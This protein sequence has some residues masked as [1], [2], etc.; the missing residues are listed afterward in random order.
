MKA[1]NII[2]RMTSNAE[3]QRKFKDFVQDMSWF[4][5]DKRIEEE[6]S[7]GFRP[8]VHAEILL[9]NWLD[10]TTAD[11]VHG[12]G[13]IDHSRFWNDWA[14]IGSSKPT[15][16]LCAYYFQAHRS[17][18]GYRPSHGNLYMPWRGPDVSRSTVQQHHGPGEVHLD[19]FVKARQDI[20]NRV[21][22]L[23]REEA[24]DVISKK[25]RSTYKRYDSNTFS[26]ALSASQQQHLSRGA[27]ASIGSR[28][29]EQAE[30]DDAASTITGSNGPRGHYTNDDGIRHRGHVVTNR[31]VS[32]AR[33]Y[34]GVYAVDD[35]ASVMGQMGLDDEVVQADRL[36]DS[37]RE[38]SPESNGN[39]DDDDDDDEAGGAIL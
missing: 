6:Y 33:K 21:L 22:E 11:G 10:L 36:G 4:N 30:N 8:I 35:V 27:D 28:H 3:L 31:Y 26:N 23:V 5:L 12:P 38:S 32:A 34:D 17:G 39:A 13:R 24:F 37:L 2:G 1:I 18:V 29:S 7:K 20:L 16:K 15:C 25:A 14:Y 19:K 9:L